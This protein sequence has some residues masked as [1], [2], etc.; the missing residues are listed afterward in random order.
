M[1]GLEL[2]WAFPF[3]VCIILLSNAMRSLLL[4]NMY[5]HESQSLCDVIMMGHPVTTSAHILS[6]AK[7][8]FDFVQVVQVVFMY[9]LL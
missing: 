6:M 8:C 1:S 3:A 2:E 5:R 9:F 7:S 4:V